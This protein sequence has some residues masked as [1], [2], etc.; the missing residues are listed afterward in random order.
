MHAQVG[1]DSF[2]WFQFLGCQLSDFHSGIP[3]FHFQLLFT[4]L[5]HVSS[6]FTGF[7]V[8]LMKEFLCLRRE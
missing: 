2:K 4:L 1:D 6:T 8:L 3:E 5:N 7:K